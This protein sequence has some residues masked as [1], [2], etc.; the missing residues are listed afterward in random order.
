[1]IVY[2]PP[3]HHKHSPIKVALL[4]GLSTPTTCAL[5]DSQVQFLQ[6]LN[7]P[8]DC[9]LYWNF[10]YVPCPDAPH[11]DPPLWLASLQNLRQFL[12]ASGRRYRESAQRHW[13]GLLASTDK[14]VIVT[15]SCGL[16]ILNQCLGGPASKVQLH[17][18]ALGPVAWR[19]PA[20]SCTLIQGSNDHISKLFFR[21]CDLK[22]ARVGHMDY[23]ADE[24]VTQVVNGLL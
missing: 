14:L 2:Q 4:S 23:L 20:A 1:M 5:S 21:D 12:S 13:N 3:E 9:K 11:G 22:L 18:V 19:K 6:R 8:E 7:A 24:R 17:I 10:P 16:E 15:L